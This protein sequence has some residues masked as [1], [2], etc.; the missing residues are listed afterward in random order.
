[1][2]DLFI[3][4]DSSGKIGI[5]VFLE[6]APKLAVK[7]ELT[8][9]TVSISEAVQVLNGF[10]AWEDRQDRAGRALS[11]IP[12]RR[13]FVESPGALCGHRLWPLARD[14]DLFHLLGTELRCASCILPEKDK[15][16]CHGIGPL[17]LKSRLELVGGGGQ[18]LPEGVL[19]ESRERCRKRQECGV[20]SSPLFVR[21]MRLPDLMGR[22]SRLT[23]TKNGRLSV[24][25]SY[26]NLPSLLILSASWKWNA[27]TK[28]K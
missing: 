20:A 11:E 14:L 19:V 13:G 1:M 17:K 6:L 9:A 8:S 10:Y 22:G 16:K 4:T 27:S 2:Y 15:S 24:T 23:A 28:R 12:T 25:G 7:V 26:G 18:R 21:V 3:G 5:V